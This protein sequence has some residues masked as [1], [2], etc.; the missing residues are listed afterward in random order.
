MVTVDNA[1]LDGQPAAAVLAKLRQAGLRPRMIQQPDGHMRPGTVI[2][3]Q[4]AGL[5]PAGSAVTV[6]VAV[7]PP[8]HGHHAVNGDSGN[9]SSGN[10]NGGNGD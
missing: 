7:P 9:G 4:P 3:V 1:A 6:T 2:S 8:G 5:V 10:G